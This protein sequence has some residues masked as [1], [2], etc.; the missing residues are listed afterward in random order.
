MGQCFSKHDMHIPSQ[1]L[2]NLPSSE[3][4]PLV[5]GTE[6]SL[7]AAA[8]SLDL[9]EQMEETEFSL[10]ALSTVNPSAASFSRGLAAV[11][12][13]VQG[14]NVR[15]TMA[16]PL[17]IALRLFMNAALNLSKDTDIGDWMAKLV[18]GDLTTLQ[19]GL[20]KLQNKELLQ[21]SDDMIKLVE[22][23]VQISE[24][25]DERERE[26]ELRLWMSRAETCLDHAHVSKEAKFYLH[27]H[28]PLPPSP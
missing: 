25:E 7:G 4:R 5:D 1:V 8:E 13:I 28:S 9:E 24:I 19:E 3:E 18:K 2:P 14:V 12:A 26:N 22:Q 17:E 21:A 16:A 10:A 15:V 20:T 23:V 11:Q 27:S 6:G